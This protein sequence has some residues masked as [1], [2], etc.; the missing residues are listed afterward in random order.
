MALASVSG[1][2]LKRGQPSF[3]D[4]VDSKG[5]LSFRYQIQIVLEFYLVSLE[6][7]LNPIRLEFC[8]LLV[9]FRIIIISNVCWRPFIGNDTLFKLRD[10][11]RSLLSFFPRLLLLSLPVDHELSLDVLLS[12]KILH[13]VKLLQQKLNKLLFFITVEMIYGVAIHFVLDLHH[14]AFAQADGRVLVACR[15]I[16]DEVVDV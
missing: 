7:V 13:V 2:M 3:C 5:D 8:P 9:L 15:L 11:F 6:V 10:S 16:H 12:I 1:S 14:V 4:D